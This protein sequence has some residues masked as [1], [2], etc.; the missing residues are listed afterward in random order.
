[1]K[2]INPKLKKFLLLL[3]TFVLTCTFT[4]FLLA[5]LVL[6]SDS[7]K[8]AISAA[9]ISSFSFYLLRISVN[10]YKQI[11]EEQKHLDTYAEPIECTSNYFETS[12]DTEVAKVDAMTINGWEFEK[13]TAELL[14]KNGF[15][16]AETT[17][18]SN[19][20][21]VDVIAEKDGIKYAIQCKCYSNKLNN[22]PVQ[23]VLAGM[24]YYHAHVGVVFTN[25]YFTDN[26]KNLANANNVL[27]WDREKLK[28]FISNSINK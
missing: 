17:P 1:M 2:N 10:H 26:A 5:F 7:F 21:G 19:D 9:I 12:L 28:E 11:I 14:L 18:K 4:I 23:E 24:A 20:Y 6:F 8:D 27:L 13:Y 15:D 22:K 25:N 16:K 3:S